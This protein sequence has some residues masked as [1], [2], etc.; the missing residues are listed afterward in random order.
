MRAFFNLSSEDIA[1]ASYSRVQS[2]NQEKRQGEKLSGSTV[3]KAIE[4][5]QELGLTDKL[6]ATPK[7]R[8]R[9]WSRLNGITRRHHTLGIFWWYRKRPRRGPDHT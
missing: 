2:T 7:Q 1:S 4:K 8:S 3:D 5:A 9:E 6:L